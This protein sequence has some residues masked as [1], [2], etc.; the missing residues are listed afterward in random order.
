MLTVNFIRK[1]VLYSPTHLFFPRLLTH[2]DSTLIGGR[3]LHTQP[4]V[5]PRFTS[6]AGPSTVSGRH[7]NLQKQPRQRNK[8]QLVVRSAVERCPQYHMNLS[9]RLQCYKSLL[10]KLF[11]SVLL[12]FSSCVFF[13]QSVTIFILISV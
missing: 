12:T 6:S 2:L 8:P 11:L 9:P 7:Q 13:R 1:H 5:I 4:C 10:I 3:A